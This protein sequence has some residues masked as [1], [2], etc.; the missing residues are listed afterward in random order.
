MGKCTRG[1]ANRR[2]SLRWQILER[3]EALW[4]GFLQVGNSVQT[5]AGRNYWL[6]AVNGVLELAGHLDNRPVPGETI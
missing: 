6:T 4:A 5:N 2:Q 1:T 3:S